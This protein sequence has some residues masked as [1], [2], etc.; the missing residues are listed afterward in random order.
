MLGG[1]NAK[2]KLPR[3]VDSVALVQGAVSLWC[4]SAKIP[5]DGA[6]PGYFSRLM[7]DNKI[8]GPIVTTQ[9]KHDLAVGVLYLIA[10][11]YVGIQAWELS[12][13]YDILLDH[14]QSAIAAGYPDLPQTRC[15]QIRPIACLENPVPTGSLGRIKRPISPR[16]GGMWI[17]FLRADSIDPDAEGDRPDKTEEAPVLLGHRLPYPLARRARLGNGGAWQKH[18]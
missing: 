16:D 10:T 3:P 9:S 8:S 6:G 11:T 7:A 14:E 2:G 15:V 18:H 12:R 17:G 13:Q 5:F 1:P 4:Y